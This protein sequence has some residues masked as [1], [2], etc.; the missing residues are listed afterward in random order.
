MLLVVQLLYVCMYKYIL[1]AI[2]IP[3]VYKICY[4]VNRYTCSIILFY[5]ACLST[6]IDCE[7]KKQIIIY[8][9]L[10][11]DCI[12]YSYNACICTYVYIMCIH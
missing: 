7:K 10:N 12:N 6:C 3:I 9:L 11:Y 2:D 1:L 4:K 8:I 5:D